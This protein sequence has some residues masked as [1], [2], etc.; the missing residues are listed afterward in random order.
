MARTMKHRSTRSL[1]WS[2]IC[3]WGIAGCEAAP[4]K[5]EIE[6]KQQEQLYKP[7]LALV[8]ESRASV[9]KFLETKLKREYIHPTDRNL[10]GEELK[11]WRHQVPFD[12]LQPHLQFL[13]LEVAVR[14]V[15][16]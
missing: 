13:A 10:E 15:D 9:E 2:L 7:L 8:K 1:G 16:V 12:L 6:R 11:M 5:Q 14:G 3:L 4:S